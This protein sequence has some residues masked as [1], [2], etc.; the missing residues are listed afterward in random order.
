MSA[1]VLVIGGL[2][3]QIDTVKEG[4]T[5]RSRDNLNLDLGFQLDANWI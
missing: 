3:E 1:I 2:I 4:L 5:I